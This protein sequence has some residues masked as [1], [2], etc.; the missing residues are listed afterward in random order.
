MPQQLSALL[1][2]C[3]RSR[4]GRLQ[5]P[6]AHHQQLALQQLLSKQISVLRHRQRWVTFCV[7]L[8][9][10]E[11]QCG[12]MKSCLLLSVDC[13]HLWPPCVSAQSAIVNVSA[14]REKTCQAG[15]EEAERGSSKGWRRRH[16][17]RSSGRDC[18]ICCRSS[19]ASSRQSRSRGR[20]AR[21]R[22]CCITTSRAVP[23]QLKR[24]A[25]MYE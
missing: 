14:G 6:A 18:K 8:L 12:C 23:F 17:G 3:L 15:E 13:L 4:Q 7:C 20:E 1:P 16:R 2:Q 10:P 22:W 19:N 24:V 9:V 5:Q 11:E 25:R 21:R